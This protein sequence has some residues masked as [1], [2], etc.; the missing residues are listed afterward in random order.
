MAYACTS[1][2]GRRASSW[3]LVQVLAGDRIRVEYFAGA[4]TAPAAFRAAG[5]EYVR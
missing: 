1:P 2:S 5:Q 3:L 4:T